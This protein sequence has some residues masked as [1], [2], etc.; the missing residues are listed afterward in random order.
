MLVKNGRVLARE[1]Q[2]GSVAFRYPKDIET[3]EGALP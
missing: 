1:I 3:T 2:R